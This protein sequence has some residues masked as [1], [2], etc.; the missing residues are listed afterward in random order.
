MS[1]RCTPSARRT[2]RPA[3][4]NVNAAGAAKAS[5]ANQRA[6]VELSTRQSPTTL[7]RIAVVAGVGDVARDGEIHRLAGTDVRQAVD[8][9]VADGRSPPPGC[10]YA[11]P[12]SCRKA[13]RIPSSAPG[14]GE[15]RSWRRCGRPSCH[16]GSGSS[17]LL[18]RRSRKTP[19][20]WLSTTCRPR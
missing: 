5:L 4:P 1:T 16:T 6:G 14:C 3:L 11:A 19:D 7:G 20:R 17:C 12:C 8:L 18:R 2:F 10:R 9:P 15:R 13:G